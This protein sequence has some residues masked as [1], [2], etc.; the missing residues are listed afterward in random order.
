MVFI[1]KKII[2]IDIGGSTTKIVGFSDGGELIEPMAVKA[3]DPLTSAY[4]AFGK[5][6]NQNKIRLDEVDRVMITGVGS[7]YINKDIF[8]LP[9]EIRPEFDASAR[10]DFGFPD[11]TRQL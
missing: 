9:C 6:T 1:M 4:G 10:V 7:S 11:L 3:A 2:G 5:F 8:G